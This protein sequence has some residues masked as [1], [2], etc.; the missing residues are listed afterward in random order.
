MYNLIIDSAN[1]IAQNY[2]DH[3]NHCSSFL[4]QCIASTNLSTRLRDGRQNVDNCPNGHVVKYV[5]GNI[6]ITLRDVT[7]EMEGIN[8]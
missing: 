1:L 8:F 6:M 5:N 4:I 2:G 7:G 3:K